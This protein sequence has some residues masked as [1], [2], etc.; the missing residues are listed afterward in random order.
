MFLE[1][2]IETTINK[3]NSVD[4]GFDTG[5]KTIRLTQPPRYIWNSRNSLKLS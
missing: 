2:R 4:G 5:E 3:I 1:G